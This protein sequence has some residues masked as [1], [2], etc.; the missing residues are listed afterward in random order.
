M[1]LKFI[2]LSFWASLEAQE[3]TGRR[4]IKERIKRFFMELIYHSKNSGEL[5]E[6]IL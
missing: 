1:V 5:A 4:V 3:S 6:K 2:T